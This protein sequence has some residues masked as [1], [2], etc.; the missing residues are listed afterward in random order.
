LYSHYNDGRIGDC[1][2]AVG[3]CMMKTKKVIVSGVGLL[4]AFL[5]TLASASDM[6]VA[7]RLVD[8]FYSYDQN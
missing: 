1:E 6:L 4:A 8:S 2:E 5:N 7:E 3:L